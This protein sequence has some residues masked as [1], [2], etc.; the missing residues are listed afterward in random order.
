VE[1]VLRTEPP[2]RLSIWP[3]VQGGKHMSDL[4]IIEQWGKTNG[5]TAKDIR[6]QCPEL[7]AG[8]LR[9]ISELCEKL[10]AE[11]RLAAKRVPVRESRY[12][13]RSLEKSV[14]YM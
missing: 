4:E 6:T 1:K 9:K 5:G 11:D 13:G 14:R 3:S 12:V 10:V 8:T 7:K 2:I